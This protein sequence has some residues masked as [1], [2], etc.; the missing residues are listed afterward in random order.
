MRRLI[1]DT[2][3]QAAALVMDLPEG[4]LEMTL[5][6]HSES[7]I[8]LSGAGIS[9]HHARLVQA[10]GMLFI[11]DVGSSGGTFV[12]GVLTANQ[13]IIKITDYKVIPKGQDGNDYN[14]GNVIEFYYDVT[15]VDAEE[16]TAS[17]AWIALID[18]IQD[19]DPNVVNRLEV[20]MNPDGTPDSDF[21]NIKI[22]GTVS[23]RICYVLTD[24][25]TPV[26]LKAGTM[27]GDD[28]GSQTFEI[29]K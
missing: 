20:G 29:K 7:N 12:N 22:G 13:V 10:N 3:A 25:V 27:A 5:G 11:E 28:Y 6:R 8:V 17:T 19:N 23:S 21:E 4:D 14:D 15:N 26:V 18:A 2:P 9:R 24:N 1:V 16:L